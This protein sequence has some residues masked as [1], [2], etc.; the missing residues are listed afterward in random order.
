M[1]ALD[2]S[3]VEDDRASVVALRYGENDD[4]PRVVAKGYGDIAQAIMDRA[5]KHGLHVHRSPELVRLLMRV[6]LDDRIPPELYLA[7]AELL[8]WVYRL[9]TAAEANA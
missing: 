8:A 7:V 2:R 6:D 5:Q 3:N 1:S 9:E 4:A